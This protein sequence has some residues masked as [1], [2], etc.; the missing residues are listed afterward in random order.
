MGSKGRQAGD[1]KIAAKAEE[2]WACLGLLAE[3]RAFVPPINWQLSSWGRNA[4]WWVDAS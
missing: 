2:R 4:S 3:S 1:S